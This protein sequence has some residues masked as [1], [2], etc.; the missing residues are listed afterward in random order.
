MNAVRYTRLVKA[1][2]RSLL[3]PMGIGIAR[4]GELEEIR[5]R[6]GL[7]DNNPIG[8][9]IEFLRSIYPLE[10]SGVDLES[11][12]KALWYFPESRSQ[13]RQDLFVLTQLNFKTEGY[14]VEFGATNGIDISNTYLLEKRFGW[15]GILAEPAAVWH[16]E[17]ERNRCANIEK[18]CV[19]AESDKSLLF[20]EVERAGLSTLDGFSDADFHGTAR[21]THRQYEVRTIS[22][23]DL[24]DQ[25][26]APQIIDFLSIDCEGSEFAILENFDFAKYRFRVIVCE[27]NF[28]PMR[29]KIYQ[30]LVSNGYRRVYEEFSYVDDWY[31]DVASAR[32]M[33]AGSS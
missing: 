18:R 21:E 7:I 4:Y 11:L 2:V 24:L 9:D 26:H 13:Y 12:R 29:E 32:G 22:L 8:S 20:N 28:T 23:V 3:K 17:L 1:V 27:H 15:T 16:A 10:E 5:A 25:H 30:L 14:F 33:F 19:W 6:L 31:V